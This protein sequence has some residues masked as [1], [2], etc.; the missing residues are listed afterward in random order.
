MEV[1]RGWLLK[2]FVRHGWH[3]ATWTNEAH[4]H[5]D[6]LI[7]RSI[8][9]LLQ[10]ASKNSIKHPLMNALECETWTNPNLLKLHR[11]LQ[12]SLRKT[13]KRIPP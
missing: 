5:E 9:V 4:T 3:A 11:D 10:R 8:V 6:R 7:L 13:R 12:S 1:Q 2:T